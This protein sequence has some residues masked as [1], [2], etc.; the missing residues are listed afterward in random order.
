MAHLPP[1]AIFSPSLARATIAAA[2]DW[3]FVDAWLSSKYAPKSPPPF[4]RNSETLKALLALAALNESADEERELLGRVEARALQEL[5]SIHAADS[6]AELTAAIEENL[7][8]EGESSLDALANLS[9]VLKQPLPDIERLGKGV[10]DL[11]VTIY[12]LDQASDRITMLE[13]HLN[14]ELENINDMIKEL[15][16]DAYQPPSE[17]TKQTIEYQ[18]KAK[19]LASK[20]PE[21]RDRVSSLAASSGSTN[22]TIQ[23]M[24]T[25]EE[26][27]KE[28]MSMV[29][30]LE[31]KVKSYQGLPQ[32]SDLARLEL[33]GLR[34]E[35]RD[36][37]RQRDSMF[38]G[39]VERE[40]PQKKRS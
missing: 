39:L 27:Y 10:L 40:S 34:I 16:G 36:L 2:K 35:L 20:L 1:S 3:N 18:R 12:D 29:Q 4:E 32:D 8:R 22:I 14:D 26:K 33:E 7:T 11:Q 5:E 6:H 25:E 13:A 21:L 23:D 24:T 9:I 30:E 38:E 15:Q 31:L 19:T 17:M 37:T 28:A